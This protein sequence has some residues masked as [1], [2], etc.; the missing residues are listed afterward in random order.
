M[1]KIYIIKGMQKDICFYV[2]C[3]AYRTYED[4]QSFKKMI[5]DKVNAGC[6]EL[7]VS[8]TTYTTIEE[9]IILD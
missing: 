7:G 8:R 4:A 5:D 1:E 6:A 2:H 3:T 9:L